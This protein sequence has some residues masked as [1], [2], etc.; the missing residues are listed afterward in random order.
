VGAGE[1]RERETGQEHVTR[2]QLFQQNH[3]PDV[4]RAQRAK[5]PAANDPP[6]VD[7]SIME[8][9]RRMNRRSRSGK[10]TRRLADHFS[11]YLYPVQAATP[12]EP[13]R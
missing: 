8:T 3:A 2:D 4:A 9:T 12:A 1:P 6:F 5:N 7:N 10:H 13:E 11:H